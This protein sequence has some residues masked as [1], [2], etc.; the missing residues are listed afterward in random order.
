M[1]WPKTLLNLGEEKLKSNQ[2]YLN[3]ILNI[4]ISDWLGRKQ[5]NKLW[6]IIWKA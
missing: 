6:L 2:N 3:R 1:S 5:K 4:T